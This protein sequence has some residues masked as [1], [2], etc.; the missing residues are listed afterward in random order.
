MMHMKLAILYHKTEDH[1]LYRYQTLCLLTGESQVPTYLDE[2]NMK[3]SNDL[4]G[5]IETSMLLFLR[6]LTSSFSL[7]LLSSLVSLDL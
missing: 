5:A 1:E 6:L 3:S 2:P 7:T 4:S